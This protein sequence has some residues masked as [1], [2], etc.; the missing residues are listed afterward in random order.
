MKPDRPQHDPNRPPVLSPSSILPTPLFHCAF[1]KKVVFFNFIFNFS[2]S[3][4][5]WN[6]V[7][8]NYLNQGVSVFR[9]WIVGMSSETPVVL[10]KLSLGRPQYLR[11]NPQKLTKTRTWTVAFTEFLIYYLQSLYRSSELLT[12]S[13]NKVVVLI[14]VCTILS[15]FLTWTESTFSII[16]QQIY[17]FLNITT[18]F[19]FEIKTW[20]G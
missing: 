8:W 19:G 1:K 14:F 17:L 5:I 9:L 2:K 4:Y 20:L 16:G 10:V 15:G 7:T 12:V 13:L 3:A 18:C 11:A 6:C